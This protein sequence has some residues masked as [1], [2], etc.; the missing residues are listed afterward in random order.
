MAGLD[1]LFSS[2][3]KQLVAPQDPPYCQPFP[4]AMNRP[5]VHS[6][7]DCSDERPPRERMKL[8]V[9]FAV[10]EERT[11]AGFR[12]SLFFGLMDR[13]RAMVVAMVTAFGR[14][15]KWKHF[16]GDLGKVIHRTQPGG[17]K[18]RDWL[19]ASRRV[20]ELH[21]FEKNRAVVRRWRAASEAAPV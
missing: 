8:I 4:L 6:R 18:R 15:P 17:H 5:K 7:G 19:R 16:A 13:V 3:A 21:F 20:A 2:L 12:G 9:S 14:M 1:L 11:A 10:R